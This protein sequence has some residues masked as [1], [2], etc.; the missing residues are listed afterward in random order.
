MVKSPV[1]STAADTEINTER[2]KIGD[3]G[4]SESTF[5]TIITTTTTTVTKVARVNCV[6]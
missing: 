4:D 1:T 2:L 5:T 6:D 3:S